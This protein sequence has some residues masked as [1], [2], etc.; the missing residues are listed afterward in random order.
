MSI[1]IA[2]KNNFF[3]GSAFD[4]VSKAQS[5]RSILKRI[6]FTEE[7]VDVA[8]AIVKMFHYDKPVRVRWRGQR[9]H[10]KNHTIKSE[11]THFDVY[12]R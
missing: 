6:P 1:S 12:V 4:A 5:F 8:K 9:L 11:A 10:N 7:N 2:V 3:N